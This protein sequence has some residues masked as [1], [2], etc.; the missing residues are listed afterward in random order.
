MVKP[1][2]L[3]MG[4]PAFAVPALEALVGHGYPVIGVVTQPD[5]PQGRGRTLA[6]PPVK[7]SALSLGIPILQ[8]EKVRE[9]AFLDVFRSLAPDLVVLAAFGQIL[10]REI[11]SGPRFGCINIHPS[12]LPQYRGAA[13]I[14]RALIQ[15][16]ERTGVTIMQMEEGIDS[17]AILLQEETP[18]GAEETSGDLHAR[19][20]A[21]G[22]ELLLM[23]LAM[24]QSGTLRPR[25]QDH[26]LA[27]FAPRISREDGRIDWKNNC[28]SIVSLVRGLSP[29]PCAYTYWEEK[30]WKIFSAAAKPAE[31]AIKPG[32]IMEPLPDGLPIAAAGGYV[33]LREVQMAGKKRLPIEAFLR[34]VRIAP[35][36]V[37]G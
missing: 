8:P 31:H 37:L 15:G 18:I 13:P 26:G 24:L 28:R 27:T 30:Q 29:D 25:P 35:G 22:A 20:A 17:G 2:I 36:T 12:L 19:L 23:T 4:T 14:Q 34:G 5:R 9:P 7:D 32:T 10:P 33:L 16:E 6:A 21:L 1:R 11:I 3:Y